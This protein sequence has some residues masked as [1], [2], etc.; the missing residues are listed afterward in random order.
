MQRVPPTGPKPELVLMLGG[1]TLGKFPVVVDQITIGRAPGNDILIDNLGVSRQHAVVKAAEGRYFLEDLG[2]ANG[3]A[4]NGERI[5]S[6]RELQDGDQI[7]IV[8]HTI[9]FQVPQAPAA[10]AGGPTEMA[11]EQTVYMGA[12]A[13]VRPGLAASPAPAAAAAGARPGGNPKLVLP[14]LSEIPLTKASIFIGSGFQAD[15]QAQGFMIAKQHVRIDRDK[16]GR[17]RFVKMG[18]LGFTRI[19]NQAVDTKPLRDGDVIEIGRTKFIF[20]LA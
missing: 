6:P 19:N 5:A 9:L 1:K 2:S 20:R 17:C 7:I 3:T 14:D 8:K 10:A 18:R 15:V 12:A 4:V 16:D 13:A 11:T